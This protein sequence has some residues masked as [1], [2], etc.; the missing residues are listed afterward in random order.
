MLRPEFGTSL[1]CSCSH[2][3]NKSPMKHHTHTSGTSSPHMTCS[4]QFSSVQFI[5]LS[6]KKKMNN[7]SRHPVTDVITSR[8]TPDRDGVRQ[9]SGAGGLR[10]LSP[11]RWRPICRERAAN[12]FW[13]RARRRG[14]QC[15][16]DAAECGAA[17]RLRGERSRE[18]SVE[19]S[20]GADAPRWHVL[21][22]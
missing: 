7:M 8:V 22:R 13:L 15:G 9:R 10:H 17:R 6:D 18:G 1:F 20:R 3:S 21:T 19:E 5:L 12:G 14:G 11:R 16:A 4:V 2:L